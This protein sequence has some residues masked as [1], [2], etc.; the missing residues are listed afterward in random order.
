MKLRKIQRDNRYYLENKVYKW[1]EKP[2]QSQNRKKVMWADNRSDYETSASEDS[3]STSAD[4]G[5]SYNFRPS[6]YRNE[7]SQS[8][9]CQTQEQRLKEN[10]AH[11]LSLRVL[12]DEEEKLLQLGLSFVYNAFQTRVDIFKLIRNVKLKKMGGGY[13]RA[14]QIAIP[15]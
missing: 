14:K 5:S 8:F 6:R 2:F 4:E 7:Y 15:A 10:L 11:N 9:F 1:L 3:A 13:Y 12:K